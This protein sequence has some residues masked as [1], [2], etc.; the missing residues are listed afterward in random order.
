M[1]ENY[2]R[3]PKSLGRRTEQNRYLG[4][5]EITLEHKHHNISFQSML[6]EHSVKAYQKFYLGNYY[7]LNKR[8]YSY[9]ETKQDADYLILVIFS[10]VQS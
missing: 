3:H 8:T 10:L 4:V 7:Y 5:K 6:S 1:E 9:H 2:V